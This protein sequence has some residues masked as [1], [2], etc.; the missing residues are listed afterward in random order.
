MGNEHALTQATSREH[1]TS[2]QEVEQWNNSSYGISFPPIFKVSQAKIGTMAHT[3]IQTLKRRAGELEANLTCV[4]SSRP[5]QSYVIKAY[6]SRKKKNHQV[7]LIL[8][9]LLEFIINFLAFKNPKIILGSVLRYN[10]S[11][12]QIISQRHDRTHTHKHG[13]IVKGLKTHLRT[14]LINIL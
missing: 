11:N 7:T 13:M 4:A 3:V 14:F 6:L 9:Q 5:S 10:V 12:I 2:Q 1:L 8:R